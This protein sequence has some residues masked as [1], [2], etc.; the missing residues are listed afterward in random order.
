MPENQRIECH[1]L[2][3]GDEFPPASY[4]MDSSM[5]TAYLKAVEETSPLYQDTGLVPPMAVA[6]S[7]MTALSDSISFPAGAIHV[8]QEVEFIDTTTTQDTL[9][10]YAKV[11]RKQDRGKF[12]ILTIDLNVF[13][14]KQQP[15][16]AGRTT[17]ILPDQETDN[18]L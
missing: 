13:N 16:L 10:S 12:H 11:N 9:T 1:Q 2:K 15:V 18:R 5:V 7:A 14:Q 4:Q 17:F 3:A 6:A 8:S